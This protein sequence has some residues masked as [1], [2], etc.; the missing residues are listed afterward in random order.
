MKKIKLLESKNILFLNFIDMNNKFFLLRKNKIKFIF[1]NTY[2]DIALFFYMEYR[3]TS[4]YQ[5][6]THKMTDRNESLDLMEL[7]AEIVAAYVSNNK[8]ELTE[9]PAFIQLVHRSLCN[10]GSGK[11][12]LHSSRGEPAVPIEDSI[13]PDY[14]VCL[15]DGKPMKMLKRH[16]KTA[17]NMTPD[18]YRERWNLPANYPMVAPNYAKKRSTIARSIGLGT[19]RKNQKKAAA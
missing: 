15:E 7:V 14:I 1:L 19:H 6:E 13:K 8:M 11:S 4:L 17:Y 16:L 3:E 5:K 18:Q 10:V 12:F 2:K 9:L